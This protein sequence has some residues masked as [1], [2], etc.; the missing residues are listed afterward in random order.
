MPLIHELE[1]D[2]T[3]TFYFTEGPME[4]SPPPGYEDFFGEPPH[5]CFQT[6]ETFNAI[7]PVVFNPTHP[8]LED[9]LSDFKD[10]PG[11]GAIVEAIGTLSHLLETEGPFDGVL[12]FSE[13]SGLAATLLADHLTKSRAAGKDSTL[14]L[15]IFWGGVPPFT[16][17]GKRWY[18]PREDG[19][20]F[21]VR[22]IH[23]IGAMDPFLPAGMLLYNLCD[24]NQATLFDHG[25]GHQIVWEPKVVESLIE[26]IREEIA[27]VECRG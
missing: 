2:G 17:D 19:Q 13:G 7:F 24:P 11:Y 22:T 1:S 21:D 26:V 8:S 20:V 23:V 5:K 15:G 14:K 9:S 3:A 10:Y 4:V 25:K 6:E 16:G 18:L 27:A 12:G